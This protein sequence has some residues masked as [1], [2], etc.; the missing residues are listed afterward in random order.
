[1]RSF[2]I[3]IV[4]YVLL[5]CAHS[6]FGGRA[7][8]DVLVIDSETLKPLPNVK[9][10]GS[11]LNYSR[12]WG[13]AAKDNDVD[14][15]TDR[16]G[17][18]RLSGNTEKGIGGYR[19]YGTPNYYN[20]E[21]KEIR[22]QEQSLLRLGAW[23]PSGIVSTVRLDRVIAPI[24]LIVN[25][26]RIPQ[27]GK[28]AFCG[29]N[30]MLSYDLMKNDWLPPFG[31]G[32]FADV[33]FTSKKTLLGREPHRYPS[34]IHTN[35]FYRCDVSVAFMGDGNGMIE[36]M[37]SPQAGIKLRVA[38][39]TGYES[40]RICWRGRVSRTEYKDNFDEDRCYYFRIRT[41]YD[42]DG[43]IRNALYGKIY[44][45]FR[46]EDKKDGIKGISFLYY[47]N[48]TPND[49]NLEWDMKMNLCPNPGDIG[50]P[51]P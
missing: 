24:P 34:G 11:F 17:L 33:H 13:I 18:A 32:C 16:H 10:E 44:G 15:W 47:L 26:G 43:K 14:A 42:K 40:E 23:Q 2:S 30:Q 46:L 5:S 9:V 29:E 48:P 38:P 4:L 21:W 8:F 6:L 36:V 20:A 51:Q 22:F 37:P 31:Q 45:D 27:Y 49:R 7:S 50:N 35:E 41:E 25:G 19:I 3:G 12:G 1:M 39:E 28:D